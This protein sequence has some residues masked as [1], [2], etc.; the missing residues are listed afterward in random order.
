MRPLADFTA[1]AAAEVTTAL[2]GRPMPP[3]LGGYIGMI[4][5]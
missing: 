2:A 5:R 4:S 3:V 1:A